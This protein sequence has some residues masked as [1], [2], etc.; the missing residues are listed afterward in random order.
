MDDSWSGILE[1]DETILWQGQPEAGIRW[2][3]ALGFQGFF[4]AAFAAFALFW[5]ATASFIAGNGPGFPFNLF[6][7]FGLP[8]L[9][10]GLYL[11][12]G[13]V[14]ADAYIRSTTWYTL[15]DRSAFIAT[16][17]FGRRKLESFRIRDMDMLE[18]E[19][20]VPGSVIFKEGRV[21]PSNNSMPRRVG[22]R[23][24]IAAREVY[25]QMREARGALNFAERQARD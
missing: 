8:F 12:A 11:M 19:D 4:G 3:D 9:F 22:F 15:T 24:I 2:R 5:M 16:N 7:L 14:L 21:R 18:L 25:R 13:H 20:G 17:A 23:N 1:Q 6:P 10:V